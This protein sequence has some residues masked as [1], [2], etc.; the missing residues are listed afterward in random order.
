MKIV[1]LSFLISFNSFASEFFLIKTGQN[2]SKEFLVFKNGEWLKDHSSIHSAILYKSEKG[3]IL[4]D[5]GLGTKAEDQFKDFPF[6]LRGLFKFENLNP[7]IQQL[8][9]LKIDKVLMTHLH[10]DHT[11]G[12]DDFSESEIYT[13]NEALTYAKSD[14]APSRSFI[15]KSYSSP[16]IKWKTFDLTNQSFYNFNESLDIFG[17]KSVIAV[18]LPGHAKG[19]TGY[20]IESKYFFVGDS[21]WSIKQMD[22]LMGKNFMASMVVDADKKTLL[23][24]IGKIDELRKAIPNLIIVPAHDG[25]FLEQTFPYYK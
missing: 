16:L 17:D 23:E 12:L 4:I 10:W 15:R 25:E 21:I 24:T 22:T 2:I 19:A 5:T 13:T 20:I 9:G 6:L 8:K 7:A 14:D 3:N 11:S 1:I 18:P